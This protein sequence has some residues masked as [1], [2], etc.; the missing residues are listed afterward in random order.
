MIQHAKDKPFQ[1]N[2]CDQCFLRK[3]HLFRHKKQHTGDKP[4]HC[5]KGFLTKSDLL[6]HTIQHT[7]EKPF[8]C[9]ICDKAF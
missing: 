8:K 3:E 4:F 6:R 1:C 2:F 9:D 7:G 5:A